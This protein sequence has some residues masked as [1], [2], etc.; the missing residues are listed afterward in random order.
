MS[1]MLV[2]GRE[3]DRLFQ[4]SLGYIVKPF[5]RDEKGGRGIRCGGGRGEELG[6]SGSDWVMWDPLLVPP[7]ALRD[8]FTPGPS[9]PSSYLLGAV[10]TGYYLSGRLCSLWTLGMP[11]T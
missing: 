7:T 5:A 10:V 8:E 2:P 11:L 4:T 9:M 3:E 1:V 6:L